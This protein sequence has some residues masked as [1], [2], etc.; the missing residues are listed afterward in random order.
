VT[1]E[2]PGIEAG[3]AFVESVA[4]DGKRVVVV[5]NTVETGGGGD[6]VVVWTGD[7]P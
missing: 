3:A 5:G 1:F 4:G 6:R 2:P 7:L